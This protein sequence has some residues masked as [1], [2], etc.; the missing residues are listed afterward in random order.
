MHSDNFI[1]ILSETKWKKSVPILQLVIHFYSFFFIA[2]KQKNK[3]GTI[4][5]VLFALGF[6]YS[7][8]IRISFYN[9][10]LASTQTGKT[11]GIISKIKKFTLLEEATEYII[12]HGMFFVFSWNICKSIDTAYIYH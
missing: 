12:L 2:D 1:S 9:K 10:L 7:S 5:D 8:A 3:A 11:R 6:F 4:I